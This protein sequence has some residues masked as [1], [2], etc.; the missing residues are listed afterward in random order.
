MVATLLLDQFSPTELYDHQSG[1]M[2]GRIGAG[3]RAR[4]CARQHEEAGSQA[5]CR[6]FGATTP[7]RPQISDGRQVGRERPVCSGRPLS[8]PKA[9]RDVQSSRD[10]RSRDVTALLAAATME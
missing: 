9:W 2:Q 5:E 1:A 6:R 8:M 3:W 10:F 4:A 7:R